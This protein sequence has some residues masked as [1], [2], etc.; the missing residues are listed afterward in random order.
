MMARGV[1]DFRDLLR[2]VWGEKWPALLKNNS[3]FPSAFI[4]L[5]LGARKCPA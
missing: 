2:V 5:E 1:I 4:T 3:A